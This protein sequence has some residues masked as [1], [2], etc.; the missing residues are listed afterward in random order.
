MTDQSNDRP[1]PGMNPVKTPGIVAVWIL[2]AGLSAL[3]VYLVVAFWPQISTSG[4]ATSGNISFFGWSISAGVDERL[5]VI[6]PVTGA[7]GGILHALRSLYQYVGNRQLRRSWLLMYLS[8][9]L[10]GALLALLFYIV[11]RGGL[12]TTQAS[13]TDLNIYGFAAIAALVGLFSEQATVK[14][15][16][17]FEA[18]FTKSESASDPLK[19]EPPPKGT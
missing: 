19:T 13:S 16:N 7:I 4:T 2:L 14:L 3:L 1:G 15:R 10:V 6:V 18:L 11:L 5:F 8:V 17:I 9:P 12:V